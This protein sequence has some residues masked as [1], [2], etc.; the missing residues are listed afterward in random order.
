MMSEGNDSGSG[1]A[2]WEHPRSPYSASASGA[3]P[4]KLGAAAQAHLDA[5]SRARGWLG[6]V[7]SPKNRGS[8]FWPLLALV[9]IVGAYLFVF[10]PRIVQDSGG[11]R[12]TVGVMYAGVV[13][14]MVSQRSWLDHDTQFTPL[15]ALADVLALRTS[16]VMGLVALVAQAAGTLAA[17]W[18]ID[19]LVPGGVK[20]PGP[21]A[22]GGWDEVLAAWLVEGL[23]VA[24]VVTVRLA[25]YGTTWQEN[26][27]QALVVASAN[28]VAI[29]ISGAALNPWVPL[30][31]LVVT[32]QSNHLELYILSPLGFTLAIMLLS[33]AVLWV[34][35]EYGGILPAE[36]YHVDE[37]GH[38]T[39]LTMG[40]GRGRAGDGGEEGEGARP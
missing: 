21:A 1:S 28:I 36:D 23:G 35:R 16:W 26:V 29:P 17:I 33:A 19:Q 34:R 18:S 13:L 22:P 39:V 10:G 11:D 5:T 20:P 2:K 15:P 40:A 6:D 7:L 24:L 4:R 12:L 8:I 14:F 32:G 25:N 9:E 27:P 30:A 37:H 3:K 38:Y 31:V